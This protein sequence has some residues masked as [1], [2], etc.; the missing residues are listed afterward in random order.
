MEALRARIE[1]LEARLRGLAGL[2]FAIGLGDLAKRRPKYPLPKPFD[3]DPC[4]L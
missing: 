3:R 4:K 2:V 1:E